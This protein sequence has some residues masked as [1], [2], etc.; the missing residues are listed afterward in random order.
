MG[1]ARKRSYCLQPR[2]YC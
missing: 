2:C 1:M